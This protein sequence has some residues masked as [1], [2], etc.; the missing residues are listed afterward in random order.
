MFSLL[1]DVWGLLY[2]SSV[3]H[4]SLA[5]LLTFRHICWPSPSSGPVILIIKLMDQLGR[6]IISLSHNR[7]FYI[8]HRNTSFHISLTIHCN[9]KLS[10]VSELQLYLIYIKILHKTRNEKYFSDF[11]KVVICIWALGWFC[12][13]LGKYF[14]GRKPVFKDETETQNQTDTNTTCLRSYWLCSYRY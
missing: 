13:D 1:K 11:Q 9:A 2:C 8:S 3:V 10:P 5:R 7:R 6:W 14:P 4:N 12:D